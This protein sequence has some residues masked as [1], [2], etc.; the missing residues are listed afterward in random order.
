K[1]NYA[2]NGSAN[3]VIFPGVLQPGPFLSSAASFSSTRTGWTIGAG[4]ETKLGGGWSAK[5]EYLYVDLGTV[6]DTL[7]IAI[8]PVFGAAFNT[9]GVAS[10]KTSSHV[11][12]NIVR[13]GVNYSFGA[14][15]NAGSIAADLPVKAP[16]YKAPPVA[17]AAPSWTGFYVGLNGGGS[18]GV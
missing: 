7:P 9:G 17:V 14:G 4:A 2:Y 11:T 12:D 6:T 13:V 8:N 15:S 10:T 5:F 16:I 3:P 1:D 18:I